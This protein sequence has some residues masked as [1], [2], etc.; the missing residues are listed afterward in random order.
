MCIF[1][2]EEK[3]SHGLLPSVFG[4]NLN[5]I[6][7]RIGDFSKLLSIVYLRCGN[8]A[9]VLDKQQWDSSAFEMTKK[10]IRLLIGDIYDFLSKA[11]LRAC[12]D[13]KKSR[14]E[15]NFR[16]TSPPIYLSFK[17]LF[18]QLEGSVLC[19]FLFL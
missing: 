7:I 12:L 9:I 10:N 1:L 5:L 17:N 18:V 3:E 14:K 19:E 6:C 13:E 2:L 11:Q 15:G 8:Q 4:I 16:K